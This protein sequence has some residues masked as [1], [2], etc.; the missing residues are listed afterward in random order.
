MQ[1]CQQTTEGASE[2]DILLGQGRMKIREQQVP[3]GKTQERKMENVGVKEEKS[4]APGT[5]A[6]PVKEMPTSGNRE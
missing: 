2:G 3:H 6:A 4:E 1:R 5:Q